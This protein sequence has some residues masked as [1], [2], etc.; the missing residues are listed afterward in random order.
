MDLVLMIV[1]IIIVAFHLII[2]FAT[3]PELEKSGLIVEKIH[4]PEN[5]FVETYPTIRGYQRSTTKLFL[6][7]E[8]FIFVLSVKDVKGKRHHILVWVGKRVWED[9]KIGDEYFYKEN[10]LLDEHTLIG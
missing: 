2:F 7:N 8:D 4:Q 9:G 6:D 5:M 1:V 10:E 3:Q